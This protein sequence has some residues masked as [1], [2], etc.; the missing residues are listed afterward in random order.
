MALILNGND[1]HTDPMDEAQRLINPMM[2]DVNVGV[3]CRGLLAEGNVMLDKAE[4]LGPTKAGYSV[5]TAASVLGAL[6]K[7]FD[8]AS[9][10][11]AK[12]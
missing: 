4:Q 12:V 8:A 10:P 1:D 5:A 2:G 3:L 9:R 6:A 7:C 11:G